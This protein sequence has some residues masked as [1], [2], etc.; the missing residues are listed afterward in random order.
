MA[1]AIDSEPHQL[2]RINDAGGPAARDG[3]P[4]S[5]GLHVS[6]TAVM[7][8]AAHAAA[9]GTHG[10][11]AV[12]AWY[13]RLASHAAMTAASTCAGTRDSSSARALSDS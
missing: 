2:L 3:A 4:G 10:R 12:G 9:H 8:T 11:G 13:G 7:T 6:S 5:A 1:L